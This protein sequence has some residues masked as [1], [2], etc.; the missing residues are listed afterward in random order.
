M[1]SQFS[2]IV[3]NIG[4]VIIKGS[5]LYLFTAYYE[6][7]WKLRLDLKSFEVMHGLS[8]VVL[9]VPDKIATAIEINKEDLPDPDDGTFLIGLVEDL[10]VFYKG[11]LSRDVSEDNNEN[12]DSR[13]EQHGEDRREMFR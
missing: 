4:R 10:V 12:F 8:R 2:T 6:K 3:D 9:M 5:N 7:T 13:I 1:Y 11:K